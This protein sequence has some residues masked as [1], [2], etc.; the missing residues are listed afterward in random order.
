MCTRKHYLISI[1]TQ[2]KQRPLL[3]TCAD[4]YTE[5]HTEAGQLATLK[6]PCKL[7]SPQYLP[8]A[9]NSVTELSN[10][11]ENLGQMNPLF[12]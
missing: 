1:A 2:T 3:I 4:S 6:L 9:F 11:K 5:P 10:D 8:K 7:L 12:M